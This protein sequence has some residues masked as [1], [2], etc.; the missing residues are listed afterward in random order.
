M[1]KR[2]IIRGSFIPLLA[3]A[4]LLAGQLP[5]FAPGQ[6]T[7]DAVIYP[8]A[9]CRDGISF[10][11]WADYY[12]AGTGDPDEEHAPYRVQSVQAATPVPPANANGRITPLANTL[13]LDTTV[14]VPHALQ[15]LDFATVNPPPTFPKYPPQ[16][17]LSW[18]YPQPVGLQ[19]VAYAGGPYTLRWDR[20]LKAGRQSV[21][22]SF[23]RFD[24]T[25]YSAE[26]VA[27]VDKCRLFDDEH[28]RDRAAA[29]EA[30]P[31]ESERSNA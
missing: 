17:T 4:L 31:E 28:P 10:L 5:A 29:P 15:Q 7:S 6:P 19:D 8:L 24:L 23:D 27:A 9:I 11:L 12:P 22:L 1:R 26:I 13:I 21:V 18:P 20:K 16:V 3:T 25:A 14:N 30:T 2:H